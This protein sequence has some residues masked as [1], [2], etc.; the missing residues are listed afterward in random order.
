MDHTTKTAFSRFAF[1]KVD[2]A[3]AAEAMARLQERQAAAFKLWS[4]ASRSAVEA[5]AR[6]ADAADILDMVAP[7]APGGAWVAPETTGGRSGRHPHA[8]SGGDIA[9][10]VMRTVQEALAKA[11]VGT[12]RDGQGGATPAPARLPEGARFEARTFTG[13]AG[14]RNYKVYVPSGYTGQALPVVVMLHG[15]TQNPDDFAAGTRMNAVAEA[16]DVLVVYPEQPRSANM[17]RCWNWYEPGDQQ[18]EGGEPALIAGIVRQVIAEFSADDRRVYAAGLSAG[19]AAA[20]ILAMTY[21]DLFAAIGVHSG[22]ACGSARDV[23]SAF[24]AMKGDGARATG[25]RHAVPLIVFHGDRDRTVHAANGDRV[26]A[27]GPSDPELRTAV[28][29]GRTP[30]GVDYTRTV[31]SD[32]SGRTM[33]EQ[34]VLH[35]AG[36]A[37]SGGSPAGSFTDPRGP[38]ASQEMIRF[39]LEHARAAG[40]RP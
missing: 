8:E 35:G 40:A 31:R 12:D 18:R 36:H 3:R 29:Q 20:A 28:T 6:T 9:G 2:P 19:G 13:A 14:T 38:D 5:G 1:P 26:A 10:T 25:K 17:Q 34:W 11:G 22:L 39:F 32:A 7:S 4:E 24:A 30:D 27:Q 23:P 21:P 15:C 33:V 37:W 16:R